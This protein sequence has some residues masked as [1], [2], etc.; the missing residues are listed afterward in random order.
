[1]AT[2]TAMFFVILLSTF[3]QWAML[4]EDLIKNVSA[5][6]AIIAS[7]SAADLATNDR[8]AAQKIVHSLADIANIEFAGILDTSGK[9]FALYVRPGVTMA[10]PYS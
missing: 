2:V 5:Q 10:P 4:R 9:D 1:M 7:N 3:M 8:A 6:V